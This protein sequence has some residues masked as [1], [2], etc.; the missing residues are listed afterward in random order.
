MILVDETESSEREKSEHLQ[1]ETIESERDGK[2]SV[3]PSIFILARRDMNE[4]W[5]HAALPVRR[6]STGGEG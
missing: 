4:R 3:I 5:A 1:R 2:N 6:D